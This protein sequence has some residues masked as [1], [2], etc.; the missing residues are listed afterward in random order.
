METLQPSKICFMQKLAQKNAQYSRNDKSL[1]S[2]EN[3]HFFNFARHLNKLV[4]GN[5]RLREKDYPEH[6]ICIK[7]QE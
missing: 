2:G 1:K 5:L 6:V 4:L 7:R 3:D